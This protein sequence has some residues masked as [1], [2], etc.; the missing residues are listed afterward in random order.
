MMA[1]SGGAE[2]NCPD[3]DGTTTAPLFKDLLKLPAKGIGFPPLAGLSVAVRTFSI[4]TEP[5]H[6]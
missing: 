4:Y 3:R 1:R 5:E 2:T 6:L